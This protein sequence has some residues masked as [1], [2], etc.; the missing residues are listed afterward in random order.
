MRPVALQVPWRPLV[1]HG[2]TLPPCDSWATQHFFE[3]LRI[4]NGMEWI[5]YD[6]T[7]QSGYNQMTAFRLY[8]G[9]GERG[10]GGVTN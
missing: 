7:E 8:S 4:R 6:K 3:M 5:K 1:A 10:Y 2:K 9:I